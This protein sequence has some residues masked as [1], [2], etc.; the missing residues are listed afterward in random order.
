VERQHGSSEEARTQIRREEE[1]WQK[2]QSRPQR[3]GAQGRSHPR[4]E[5][6]GESGGAEEAQIARCG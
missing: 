6:G 2:E 5:Q 3:V 1:R 4:E